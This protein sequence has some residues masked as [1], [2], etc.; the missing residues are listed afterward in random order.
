MGGCL[1]EKKNAY[2]VLM[3]NLKEGDRLQDWQGSV[4]LK[5]ILKK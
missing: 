1:A 4:L 5:L 2:R 3:G